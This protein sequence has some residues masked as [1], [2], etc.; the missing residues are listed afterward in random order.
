MKRIISI[1]LVAVMIMSVCGMAAFAAEPR[2]AYYCPRC[3]GTGYTLWEQRESAEYVA[4]CSRAD[5]YHR[6]LNVALVDK[7]TCEDCQSS[8][9]VNYYRTGIWCYEVD[10]WIYFE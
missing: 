6:H 5:Y 4:S 2:A 7:A 1:V 9:V 8:W 3:G 10:E